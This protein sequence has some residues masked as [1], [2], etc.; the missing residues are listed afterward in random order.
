M[1]KIRRWLSYFVEWPLEKRQSKLSGELSLSYRK[2]RLCLSSPNAIYSYEDLYDNFRRSFA[3]IQNWLP[4]H[5]QVLILG[6][7]MASVPFLLEKNFGKIYQYTAVEA[8]EEVLNLAK[9]YSLKMLQSP[10]E[11]VKERAELYVQKKQKQG[12]DW[13]IVDVFVNTEV[14]AALETA[15]FLQQLDSLLNTGAQIWFN[16]LSFNET[17][18]RQT[19]WFWEE[20][21]QKQF[22]N[23]KCL[24]L[25]AN[26][27]LMGWKREKKPEKM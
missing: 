7:G 14:P 1:D 19:N 25:G 2:G 23:S 13:I 4:N 11:I 6:M 26:Q 27:M 5:S 22:P 20:R 16:R 10:L 21:F 17:L 12:F 9:K 8:D 24:D 15:N 18:A 3:Q